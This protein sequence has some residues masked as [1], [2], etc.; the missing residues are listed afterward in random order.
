[1]WK[2]NSSWFPG[3]KYSVT[4]FRYGEIAFSSECKPN[5]R[6]FAQF[7]LGIA[8]TAIFIFLT[9]P[10]FAENHALTLGAVAAALWPCVIFLR[11]FFKCKLNRSTTVPLH[12]SF[13]STRV[14]E[15]AMLMLGECV[16]TSVTHS[17]PHATLQLSKFN[18][19]SM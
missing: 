11:I 8:I 13:M 4:A 6:A 1:M 16:L 19:K 15:F 12:I 14:G 7:G 9:A 2:V 17:P 3:G 18:C 5:E 10:T